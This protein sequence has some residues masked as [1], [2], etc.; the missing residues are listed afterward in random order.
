MGYGA[1][2]VCPYLAYETIE[3]LCEEGLCSVPSDKALENFMKAMTKGIVKVAS[4]M[5]ISTIQ[6][7]QGAQIFEALGISHRVIN[8][9]FTGTS[10]R[11]GG[12]ELDQI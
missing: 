3:A 1:N 2:A 9:Y 4:K 12:L 8:K 6:S 5:G 7:Y 11:I 10:S